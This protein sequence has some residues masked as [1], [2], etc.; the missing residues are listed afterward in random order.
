MYSLWIANKNYSSWSLRPW[1]LLKALDVPFKENQASFVN[2]KSSYNQFR[3]F[4][5]T[6]QVP[7]LIDHAN[8]VWD[9]LAICEYIA[10]DYP[11]SWPQDRAA[12][13]WARSACAEMHS[14]FQALR[15]L[16]PMDCNLRTQADLTNPDLQQDLKRF[17]ELWSEGLERFGG[18][19]LAGKSF[20]VVDAFF[21]PVV[22]RCQSYNLPLS[23]ACHTWYERILHRP[24]TQAWLTAAAQEPKIDH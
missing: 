3:P 6:G 21:A 24:A 2:G 8:V 23:G 10:E 22:L 20:S 9:S 13:A 7:C 12:R 19:W 18:P 1:L 5:P 14:G 17:E 11:Q 15:K 4:S 16:C